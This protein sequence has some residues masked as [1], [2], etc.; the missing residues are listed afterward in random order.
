M[1]ALDLAPEEEEGQEG[2][3]PRVRATTDHELTPV[4]LWVGSA[5]ARARVQLDVQ[6]R[7]HRA[8]TCRE[9]RA[10]DKTPRCVWTEGCAACGLQRGG[11]SGSAATGVHRAWHHVVLR[12]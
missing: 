2:D 9:E 10:A 11:A 6:G 12:V 3:V 8:W 5:R 4:T 1:L 7:S